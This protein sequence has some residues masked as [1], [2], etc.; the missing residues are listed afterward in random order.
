MDPLAIYRRDIARYRTSDDLVLRNLALALW[1]AGRFCRPGISQADLIGAANVGLLKARR[2]YDASRG[3]FASF[4]RICIVQAIKDEQRRLSGAL[5]IPQR[6]W[7]Q[8]VRARAAAL[9]AD[10]EPSISSTPA[11]EAE[12]A[13][14]LAT[15]PRAIAQLDER[16][17]R[18]VRGLLAGKDG[19]QLGEELGI[20]KQRVQQIKCRS[21]A[22]L[23][24]LVE[25]GSGG[26]R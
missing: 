11:S 1:L 10:T 4:A 18:V 14:D 3:T 21:F 24:A 12:H 17:Q 22:E 20:T 2:L 23:R 5:T 16:E 19:V 9:N 26:G 8:N 13:D 7:R 6:F 25:Q 15:L